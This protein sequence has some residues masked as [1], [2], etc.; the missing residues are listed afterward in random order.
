MNYRVK[1]KFDSK[2]CEK[3]RAT[4][5]PFRVRNCGI[6]GFTLILESNFCLTL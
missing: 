5:L 4:V 6:E 3:R 1:H 2:V